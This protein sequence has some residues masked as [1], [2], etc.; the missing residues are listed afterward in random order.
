MLPSVI[1]ILYKISKNTS[2]S[3]TKIVERRVEDMFFKQK[4]IGFKKIKEFVRLKMKKR[5]VAGLM[6]AAII[7][8]LNRKNEV[9]SFFYLLKYKRQDIGSHIV[10]QHSRTT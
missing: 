3:K 1:K 6:N 4:D 5:E 9:Y 7:R 2:N 10:N 8:I